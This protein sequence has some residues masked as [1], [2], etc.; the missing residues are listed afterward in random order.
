MPNL[1]DQRKWDIV[2]VKFGDQRRELRVQLGLRENS[3]WR[4][5]AS[6]QWY[7]CNTLFPTDGLSPIVD[8]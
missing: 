4:S 3:W 2:V 6:N 5:G 7:A 8:R 1:A